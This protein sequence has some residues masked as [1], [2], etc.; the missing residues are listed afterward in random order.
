MPSRGMPTRVVQ[1]H[2]AN[3]VERGGAGGGDSAGGG[4]I[5]PSYGGGGDGMC[6]PG[7]GVGLGGEGEG[8][9]GIDA[10]SM[11]QSVMSLGHE[12]M[13]PVQTVSLP[14]VLTQY[15]SELTTPRSCVQ[16]HCTLTGGIAG[17]GEDGGGDSGAA[18]EARRRP[19]M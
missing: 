12:Y 15:E 1:P 5:G 8:G 17:D 4:D 2:C 11:G 10:G 7:G 13:P 6:T 19:T 9:G 16:P 14:S 3:R 18:A